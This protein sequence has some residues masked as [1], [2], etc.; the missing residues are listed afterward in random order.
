MEESETKMEKL[1]INGL[2]RGMGSHLINYDGRFA[3]LDQT[4][5][6]VIVQTF[7]QFKV[8]NM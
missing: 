5:F 3:G 6:S 1:L 2:T 7:V 4:F 8:E